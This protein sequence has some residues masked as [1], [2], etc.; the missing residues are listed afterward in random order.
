[1]AGDDPAAQ[2]AARSGTE[3]VVRP[4][5]AIPPGASPVARRWA[6][7]L[8]TPIESFLHIEAASGIV[9]LVMAAVAMTIA[10]SAW[11][12]AFHRLLELP[13][14]LR[15]GAV[16]IERPLHFWINDGLMTIFFFVVGLEIRRE[17]YE[18][19]LSNARRGLLPIAAALGGMVAPALIYL[20]F[21][22]HTPEDRPGWGVPMATDIA[23][24]VGLL[25]LLGKRVPPAL[26]VLLL[27]LAIIDD[28]GSIVVI[29]TFYSGALDPSG[30]LI[31]AGGVA[32]IVSLQRIGVR[33]ASIYVIP[34]V[35]V[36][37]GVCRSGVHPTIAGVIVG[38]LTPARPWLGPEGLV[39]LARRSAEEVE[40]EL[41]A[42]PGAAVASERLAE[43]AS[44]IDL[45]SREALAPATRLQRMLH[46]WVAFVIMPIF[47]LANAGVTLDARSV[48]PSL[49]GAGIVVGLVVGKPIGI[50]AA[51]YAVV[52]LRVTSLPRGI[53]WRELLVLGLV[54]GIGFTMALFVAALAF[55]EGY[56]LEQAK[57][58]ILVAS[59]LAMTIGL[60][61]GRLLL[62]PEVARGAAK[63][64]SEAET[65]DDV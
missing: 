46:P 8:V 52:R 38:L 42:K 57:A 1:M 50:L 60:A 26:R 34:G 12:G 40:H 43:E 24:A 18:G 48:A 4:T 9:L 17:M 36:W 49:L 19:E 64:A 23:F 37:L 45:A 61:A 30:F 35:I 58:A 55:P 11:S 41:E 2:E 44:R 20:A 29:A 63:T 21:A 33:R 14:G 59:T 54:A 7:R 15:F 47:A 39:A 13:M 22:G 51:C 31:A 62:A 25:A 6:R 16:T 32:A 3:P 27:A 28:I 10:S 53:A 56:K 5:E 65:S